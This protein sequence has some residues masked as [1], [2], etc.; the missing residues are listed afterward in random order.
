MTTLVNLLPACSV[1]NSE[2]SETSS[3]LS[4]LACK[5]GKIKRR[6]V[7]ALRRN[8]GLNGSLAWKGEKREEGVVVEVVEHAA[9]AGMKWARSS[10]VG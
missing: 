7:A 4:G 10:R 8:K 5:K 9:D 2:F 1:F 6:E 3:V